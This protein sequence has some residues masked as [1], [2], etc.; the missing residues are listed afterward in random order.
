MCL[1]ISV[2]KKWE[3]HSFTI[4][5][6]ILLFFLAIISDFVCVQLPLKFPAY[7]LDAAGWKN[8]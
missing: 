6:G 8:L 1:Q 4:T 3:V 2:S 5:M 7:L